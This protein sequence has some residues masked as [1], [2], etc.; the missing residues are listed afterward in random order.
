MG[1][2]KSDNSF[3]IKGILLVVYGVFVISTIDNLLKPK[4]IGSRAEV[5]PLLVLLGV[6]GGLN[7]FGIMGIVLGPV[8]LSLLIVLINIYEE[9]VRLK[10]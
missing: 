3:V 5:H 10:Q 6:L 7:L 9:E 2:I 4:L 8:L 1:M